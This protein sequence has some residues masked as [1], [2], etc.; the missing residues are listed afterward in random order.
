MINTRKARVC[1]GFAHSNAPKSLLLWPGWRISPP[2]RERWP[3]PPAVPRDGELAVVQK[4]E[5][6]KV[7]GLF[8]GVEGWLP[9]VAMAGQLGGTLATFLCRE[10]APGPDS[11]EAVCACPSRGP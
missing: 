3:R 8:L 5:S 1:V 10:W 11:R 6:A 2:G 9:V 4:A 7:P